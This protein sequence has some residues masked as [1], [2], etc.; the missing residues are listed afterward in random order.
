M[1]LSPVVLWFSISA[2][3]AAGVGAA[4]GLGA[5]QLVDALGVAGSMAVGIIEYLAVGA[6]T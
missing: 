2:V 5:R 3:L 1:L 6:W 4:L